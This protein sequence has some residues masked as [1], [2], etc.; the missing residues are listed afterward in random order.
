M[1]FRR[2]IFWAHLVVGVATGLVIFALAFTGVMLT[3]EMQIKAAFDPRVAPAAGQ[4]QTLSADEILKIA[5]PAFPGQTATLNFYNDASRPVSVSAGRHE[6]KLINQY[7]GSFIVDESNPT[8]GFF[9]LMENIHRNLAMGFDSAGGDIVKISNVAFLFIILSGI[10]LWLPKK[11]KWPFLKQKIF[12]LK[13]PTSKARDLNWHHVFSFWVLIPLLAVVGSGAVLSY[14][15]ANDLV[16]S[17]A[18][19][20]APM[21]RGQGKGMWARSTGGGASNMPVE[22][23]VSYQT[24]L[25]KA[26]GV[27]SDWKTISIIV[28]DTD[29]AKSVDILIDTGNGKQVSTQQTITYDRESGDVTSIKGP[30]EMASPTQALKRYIRFLHTGE[31]YGVIGQTLA[32]I[33]SLACLFLVWTG[34]ALAWRRLISPLFRPKAKPS[35]KAHS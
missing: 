24:I 22:Q 17:V 2:I 3:Y 33:A 1:S 25:D 30:D 35:L 31:V 4:T 15:W 10:Y 18:G 9:G 11:W 23:L 21:G 6:A 8:E 14:Q 34:F 29:Q 26:K 16:F 32:G 5:Q 13:M 7:D 27:E 20:Q 28:P 12:F 19:L